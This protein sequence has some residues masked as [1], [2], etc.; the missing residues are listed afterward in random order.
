MAQISFHEF[1]QAAIQN[2]LRISGF[3]LGPMILYHLVG[4]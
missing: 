2:S 4:M 3:M 1:V